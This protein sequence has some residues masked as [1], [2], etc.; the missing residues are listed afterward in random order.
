MEQRVESFV[1]RT[2]RHPVSCKPCRRRKVRCD[3][4]K[5]C[6]TCVRQKQT[7]DCIY[8]PQ[9]AKSSRQASTDNIHGRLSRLEGAVQSLISK[10]KVSMQ[11]PPVLEPMSSVVTE[12]TDRNQLRQT[13]EN[14]LDGD[15]R[16]SIENNFPGDSE[17]NI[18]QSSSSHLA[19]PGRD[20]A[21]ELLLG[22]LKHIT[23]EEIIMTMP[24]RNTVDGLVSR[25]FSYMDF[26]ALMIHVPTFREEYL[27]F[28]EDSSVVSMNWLSMLF[29]MMCIAT[30]HFDVFQD[31]LPPGLPFAN[32]A[33]VRFCRH[34]AQCLILANYTK[35]THD[36]VEAL[37][38]YY[39]C[40][41][42]R[43]PE[44]PFALYLIFS[45]T[46]RIA[47]QL[48]YHR[49]PQHV[50]GISVFHGEL[51]RR[52]WLVLAQ[53]D[54]IASLQ[55]GLPRLVKETDTGRPHNLLDED[56]WPAMTELP[57]SRSDRTTTTLSYIIARMDTLDI[58]GQI[59]DE[60]MSLRPFSYER[61][62]ELD[63]SL[64]EKYNAVPLCFKG[65][66]YFPDTDTPASFLQR[67]MLELQFEKARCILHRNSM[68]TQDASY[69]ACM[70]AALNIIQHQLNLHRELKPG[71]YLWGHKWKLTCLTV[72]DFL[73]AVM[74]LYRGFDPHIIHHSVDTTFLPSS[75]PG[76]LIKVQA[77]LENS[78]A[79]WIDW[80]ADMKEAG[81]AAQMVKL[82]IKRMRQQ[83]YITQNVGFQ[84][85]DRVN[86][87]SSAASSIFN[88]PLTRRPSISHEITPLPELI[89]E[90]LRPLTDFEELLDL[91]E[92][93]NWVRL[94]CMV[95]NTGNSFP[96]PLALFHP[97]WSFDAHKLIDITN[98]THRLNS[99]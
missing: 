54:I 75:G 15:G 12:T 17:S 1:H 91:D 94:I 61:V 73:L 38:L 28:W 11:P 9:P 34:S 97:S 89:S 23:R 45:M 81:T 29:S 32:E 65:T 3:R 16:A 92:G 58:L 39:F 96:T 85:I 30:Y 56:L 95:L 83:A 66:V 8:A 36:T 93:I 71:R 10:E 24:S 74:I 49:D 76:Q 47:M 67:I 57:P 13:G 59:Q 41:L 68:F 72:Y 55:A 44:T 62:M 20:S 82:I 84:D 6:G 35:P 43:S 46:I 48:G 87:A 26:F 42:I 25:Y 22:G 31:P 7:G 79:V 99:I 37:M 52:V 53:L 51:R 50:T 86:R 21:P 90:D 70:S 27:H 77:M 78:Y 33:M 88:N 80:C 5:P 64:V 40:E 69:T 19:G 4:Q 14:L 60:T 98:S 18:Q 2:P 63:R